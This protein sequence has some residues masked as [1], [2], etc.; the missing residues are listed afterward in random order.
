MKIIEVIVGSSEHEL[1]NGDELAS[2]LGKLCSVNLTLK[3]ESCA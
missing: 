2:D 1:G 3:E